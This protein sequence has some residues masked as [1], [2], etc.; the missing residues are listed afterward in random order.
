MFKPV[1]P[2]E[3]TLSYLPFVKT[4][5][6]DFG[7]TAREPG[8]LQSV[9]WFLLVLSLFTFVPGLL[10]MS[11]PSVSVNAYL[12]LHTALEF[13][14]ISIAIIIFTVGW[15]HTQVE[16]T[17]R[18]VVL[19][20]AF[21]AVAWLDFSHTLSYPGMPDYFT[22]NSLEKAINF[23]LA[24]RFVL[25]IALLLIVL[26]VSERAMMRRVFYAA[27]AVVVLYIT[28]MHLWFLAFAESVP[29]TFIPGTGLTAFK[30]G[31]EYTVIGLHLL[32][33]L[34]VVL[35]YRLLQGFQPALLLGAVVQ[36]SLSEFFFT[37]YGN[38]YDLY[39]LAGH[40]LKVTG[41][42]F[43][44]RSF[45]FEAVT[46]PYRRLL[47]ARRTLLDTLADQHL[48]AIAFHTREAIMITD[49]QRKIIRVNPAFTDI[50]GYAES[51]VIGQNPKILSSGRHDDEFYRAMWQCIK[52]QGTWSG[53]IW[54]K[55]K[56]GEIYAEH[57]VI[58][59]V[60]DPSGNISHYI[61]SFS[62]VTEQ[63]NAQEQAH[64]LAYFDSLTGLANR[65]LIIEHIRAA[66]AAGERTGAYSALLF[67]DLD[68]FKRLN[69][70]LGHS[71]GDLLLQQFASRLQNYLRASDTLARP[72][73]DEF[74]L[75]ARN[76]NQDKQQA[77]IQVEILGNKILNTVRE[78][79]ELSGQTYSITVS[80][81]VMLFARDRLSVDELFASA[82]LAM[83]QSKE[84]GR[85]QLYFF[86]P[87]MQARL[88]E[89]TA[90]EQDLNEALEQNAGLRVYYQPK[91]D[92][93]GT[94]RGYEALVRW[95][96]PKRG[97][98]NPGDFV[99]LAE[100]TGQIIHLGRWVAQEVF[101]L[102]A[103]NK[104][105]GMQMVPIA[106][107]VSPREF[108]EQDY[109]N[110]LE[111]QLKLFDIEP[112]WIEL[113]ITESAVQGNFA[114][115]R[116]RLYVLHNMGFRLAMDDFGTGYSSLSYLQQL[117]LDVLKIDQS[118]VAHM[119]DQA[120][121]RAIITAIL[122]MAKAMNMVVVAEGV[123]TAAQFTALADQGCDL[124]QGYYWS[125]PLPWSEHSSGVQP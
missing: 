94:V 46:E 6:V 93:H 88:N 59:A 78:P 62:D 74:I 98:L 64:R 20:A 40:I 79:F 53:D 84:L 54:N 105:A 115:V 95:Q 37:L 21:F 101:R 73:G 82:D 45:F 23:W 117:P 7:R 39:N 118:F 43:L 69:D 9:L 50:T 55:R 30:I 70:T 123:E 36:L 42:G 10:N 27:T 110:W 11:A 2:S 13:A 48:S 75:L 31:A 91:V 44:F 18:M 97:F 33:A 17:F 90:I 108:L 1:L 68:Y 28:G 34:L 19:A 15:A 120:T 57:A 66:Q 86:E 16:P 109:L 65:R 5:L 87:E 80:I 116:E 29:R 4:A 26:P 119:V 58:N 99:A 60:Y 103:D 67:M 124:F 35:R 122:A 96:H 32:T 112:Q 100:S 14:A 77:A 41:Y 104:R 12:P 51:D 85:N 125:K 92:L 107:N 121:D 83:Y 113:E 63:L 22:A 81:G 38:P 3:I 56:S 89:R 61:A 25:A 71:K 24:A 52:E 106:I 8:L 111:E 72:G 76:L 102:Q 49:A 114:L 47:Q